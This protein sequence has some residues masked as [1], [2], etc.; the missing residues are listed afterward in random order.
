MGILLTIGLGLLSRNVSFIPLFIG[1][2]LYAVMFT[3]ILRFVFLSRPWNQ[4]ALGAIVVCF[5]IEFSQLLSYDIMITLRSTLLGK[6]VLGQGFLWS[7][8]LAYTAGVLLCTLSRS[9]F[10]HIS[11]HREEI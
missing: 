1:D 11:K 2:M 4:I 6:L 5:C 3:M 9:T 7:D 8:L 10:E